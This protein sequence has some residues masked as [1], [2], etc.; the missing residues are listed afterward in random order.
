MFGDRITCDYEC[1]HRYTM[2][3]VP[4]LAVGVVTVI[5]IKAAGLDKDDKIAAIPGASSPSSSDD[6]TPARR[7]LMSLGDVAAARAQ[8]RAARVWAQYS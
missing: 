5:A 4:Y 2:C 1:V 6:A 8:G 3:C 7:L